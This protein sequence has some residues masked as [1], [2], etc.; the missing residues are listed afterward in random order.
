MYISD[1]CLIKF[2]HE[3]SPKIKYSFYF[4]NKYRITHINIFMVKKED[5]SH[6]RGDKTFIS[7]YNSALYLGASNF[8][9]ASESIHL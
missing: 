3:D 1:I 6:Y 7:A 2:W 5:F 9:D 4:F 8:L